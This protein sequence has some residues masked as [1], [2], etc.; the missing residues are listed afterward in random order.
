[1]CVKEIIHESMLHVVGQAQYVEGVLHDVVGVDSV[2][3]GGSVCKGG[4]G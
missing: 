2:C 1:M 3:I 4:L